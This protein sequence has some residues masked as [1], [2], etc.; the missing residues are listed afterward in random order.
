VRAPSPLAQHPP[1]RTGPTRWLRGLLIA[2]AAGAVACQ[3]LARKSEPA[4]DAAALPP[5]AAAP[6]PLAPGQEIELFDG[7][8]LGMWKPEGTGAAAAVAVAEG[9]IQLAWGNPGTAIAWTGTPVPDSYELALEVMRVEGG[10]SGY[11][12]LTF[13]IDDARSCTLTLA[14]AMG[15]L[16]G[17]SGPGD[18]AMTRAFALEAGDWHTVRVR[19]ERGRVEAFLDAQELVFEPGASD[20]VQLTGSPEQPSLE[21]STFSMTAAVREIRMKR[22]DGAR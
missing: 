15:W 21:I 7:T 14:S 10:G 11:W 5:V 4:A 19:V 17:E 9:A 16:C 13:P 12:F 2:F 22:L 6:P 1:A 8:T 3:G 20:A 18:G